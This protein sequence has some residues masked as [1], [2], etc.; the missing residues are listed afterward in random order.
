MSYQYSKTDQQII[1]WLESRLADTE[2]EVTSLKQRLEESNAMR[3][4][5]EAELRRLRDIQP[6]P[7]RNAEDNEA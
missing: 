3:R 6:G 5:Y 2:F 4:K 1:E 7:E